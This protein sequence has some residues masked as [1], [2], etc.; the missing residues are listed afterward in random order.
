MELI[1]NSVQSGEL[2]VL[3]DSYEEGA[4]ILEDGGFFTGDYCDLC[5][6]RNPETTLED[7]GVAQSD[8]SVLPP[9]ESFRSFV[10]LPPN[11]K[12]NSDKWNLALKLASSYLSGV[13][14]F[15]TPKTPRP[16]PRENPEF[17]LGGVSGECYHEDYLASWVEPLD[18]VSLRWKDSYVSEDYRSSRKFSPSEILGVKSVK[19]TGKGIFFN[20]GKTSLKG[21]LGEDRTHEVQIPGKFNPNIPHLNSH[22]YSTDSSRTKVCYAYLSADLSAAEEPVFDYNFGQP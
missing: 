3:S 6:C 9:E 20:S 1:L 18:E 21:Y 8:V 4:P 17:Y 12:R 10:R 7:I 14:E 2:C 19:I 5:L 11:I 16:R 13:E 22:F 15:N